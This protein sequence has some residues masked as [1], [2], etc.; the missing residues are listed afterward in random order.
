MDIALLLFLIL[1][2]GFLAMSEIAVISAR[3]SRLKK[4]ADDGHSGARAALA[5]HHE[6]SNFLSTVQVGITTVGI[7]SGAS[8]QLLVRIRDLGFEK[9]CLGLLVRQLLLLGN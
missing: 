6:P 5:L 3:Q 1:L 2:N 7:L 4:L 9:S 8:G